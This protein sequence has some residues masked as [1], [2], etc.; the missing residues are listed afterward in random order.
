MMQNVASGNAG[1]H[2]RVQFDVFGNNH[3]QRMYLHELKASPVFGSV[4]SL[5][6][7][8]VE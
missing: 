8:E 2:V 6:P 1:D 4:T 3:E 7:V 5:G